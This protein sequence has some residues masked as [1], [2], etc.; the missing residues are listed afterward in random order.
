MRIDLHVHAK[1]R[2]DCAIDGEEN[3]IRAAIAH[4]LD[5]LAFTDHQR[6]VPPGRLAELNRRYAPFRVFS[7]IEITL[8][9]GED[10]LVLGVHD[11]ELEARDWNYHDLFNFAREQNGFLALAHPFRFHDSIEIPI[12]EY[13][14]NAV[15]IHSKNMRASDE[16]R[17]R[18]ILE[19]L[20]LRP[21]CNSD[22]HRAAHVGVYYNQLERMVRDEDELLAVLRA[23]AYTCHGVEDRIAEIN[24]ERMAKGRYEI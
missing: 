23:G 20:N 19:R 16:R 18:A 4:G 14:P 6:L 24:R 17:V 7:G 3:V 2:S 15:E 12:E 10:M 22:A 11:R 9:D 21:L 13:P 8:L 5:G 1:E